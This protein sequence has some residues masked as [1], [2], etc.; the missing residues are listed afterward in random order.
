MP[1]RQHGLLLGP[2]GTA[3]SELARE[4]TGRVAGARYRET[5][6]S[7]FT[8]EEQVVARAGCTR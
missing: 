4:L 5:L 2:P 7:K 8:A 3:R 1:A 6:L